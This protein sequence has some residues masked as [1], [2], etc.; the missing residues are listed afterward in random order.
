MARNIFAPVTYDGSS[1]GSEMG[2]EFDIVGAMLMPRNEVHAMSLGSLDDV[3]AAADTFKVTPSAMTVRALR[4]GM[5]NRKRATSL[6]QELRDQYAQSSKTKARQPKPINA[7]RKYNGRE[8]SRR[9]L[10]VLDAG[11]ISE[12]DFCRIVCLR[13]IK[14]REIDDFRRALR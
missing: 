12:G 3:K 1:A 9:M 14:P 5:I 11:K 10:D 7:V 2:R 8:L 13:H 6:L 4:L